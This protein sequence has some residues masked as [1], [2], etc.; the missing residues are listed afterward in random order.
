M[1]ALPEDFILRAKNLFGKEYEAFIRSL[2]SDPPVSIRLNPDKRFNSFQ[3]A[4]PVP[5]SKEGRYLDERPSF[6]FDPLFHSGCYYVQDAS[7]QFIE[8]AF[9]HIRAELTGALRILDLCAAPG[10]KSTHLL[11]LMNDDDLLVSNEI[12]NHRNNILRENILKWGKSN[13]I[14]TQ[15]DA[16]DFSSLRNFFDAILVDAPCSGE[17]LFRKDQE[18]IKEWSAANVKLCVSRQEEILSN[19]FSCLK[20][21]GFLIYSTCTF[22]DVENDMQ[23]ERLCLNKEIEIVELKNEVPGITNT[24]CGLIFYPH[25]ISGEGFYISLLRKS[26]E[27]ISNIRKTPESKFNDR[28]EKFL[29]DPNMFLSIDKEARKFAVR[30]SQIIDIEKIRKDMYV[31]LAG[32]P[33]GEVKG[34]DFIPS[35]GLALSVHL[36]NDIPKV[37]LSKEEAIQFLRGNSFSVQQ[38]KGW[39]LAVYKDYGLGW[40]KNIGTRTNNYFPKEW[41]IRN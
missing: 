17:G 24:K 35:E 16:A 29:N 23:V 13:V 9:N 8:Q 34:N 21:G 10:G 27:H 40:I 32:I 5:W 14:V 15:N 36:R 28:L 12:I 30:T 41:R 33:L 18:A 3:D 4:Q 37:E 6:T 11:S 2:S 1:I 38:S 25:K 22:E 20:P 7:S 19:I 26:G 39:I 31:R